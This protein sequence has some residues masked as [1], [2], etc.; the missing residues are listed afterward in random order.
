M[1]SMEE[2]ICR[3]DDRPISVSRAYKLLKRLLG[4]QIADRLTYTVVIPGK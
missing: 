1:I 4:K 2:T 3:I